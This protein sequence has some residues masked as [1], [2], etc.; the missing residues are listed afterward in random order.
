[1]KE[2]Y[3]RRK[4][5]QPIP[6]RLRA[7]ALSRRRKLRF[8]AACQSNPPALLRYVSSSQKIFASQIFFGS[9]V[10]LVFLSFLCVACAWLRRTKR[11]ALVYAKHT[12]RCQNCYALFYISLLYNKSAPYEATA[13]KQFSVQLLSNLV[14]ALLFLTPNKEYYQNPTMPSMLAV[15]VVSIVPTHLRKDEAIFGKLFRNGF[16]F[17]EHTATISMIQSSV[18]WP[19]LR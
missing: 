16:F 18:V 3:A 1:M 12:P 10:D 4:K 9:P 17:A 8:S 14:L 2:S 19:W 7:A 13:L 6:K 11:A 5:R 15:V